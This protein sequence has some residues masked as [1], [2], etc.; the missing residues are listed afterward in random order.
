MTAEASSLAVAFPPDLES[1]QHWL[2]TV[3]AELGAEAFVR[4]WDAGRRVRPADVP[5]LASR[6]S[7]SP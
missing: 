2:Q 6:I 7:A 1:A 4:A 5:G 3:Q